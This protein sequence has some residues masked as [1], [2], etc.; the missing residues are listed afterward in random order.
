MPPKNEHS[1]YGHPVLK[2]DEVD[3]LLNTDAEYLNLQK[4]FNVLRSMVLYLEAALIF[5]NRATGQLD[6]D[7]GRI[8]GQATVGGLASNLT[9][10]SV[11]VSQELLGSVDKLR[12]VLG[13][14]QKAE[15]QTE[16]SMRA[17]QENILASL[18]QARETKP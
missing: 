9:C 8:R 2:D 11:E 10:K 7:L 4:D 5:C 16:E 13:E 15:A 18:A 1:F 12:F 14:V 6:L 3:E 17:R